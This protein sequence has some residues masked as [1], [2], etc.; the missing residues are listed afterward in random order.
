MIWKTIRP[1]S[2]ICT[3]YVPID[4]L[5]FS[6]ILRATGARTPATLTKMYWRYKMDI[7]DNTRLIPLTQGKFTLVDADD[8]DWLTQWKWWCDS[9]GYA[10]GIPEKRRQMRLHRFILA[11]PRGLYVDH[12]NRDKLDNRRSNLR[13][14]TQQDNSRNS[15]PRSTAGRS[16]PYKGVS[17]DRQYQI[18]KWQAVIHCNGKRVHLGHFNSEIAAALAYNEAARKIFGEFAFLNEIKPGALV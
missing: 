11:A 7:P 5:G 17:I 4:I 2:R 18:E 12:I 9:T 15:P 3:P 13:V 14:C 8:Y 16:S 10:S 1:L 6:D